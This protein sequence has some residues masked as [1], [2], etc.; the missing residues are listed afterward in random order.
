VVRQ[1]TLA[2]LTAIA[3]T[4]PVNPEAVAAV[5]I[6]TSLARPERRYD[7]ESAIADALSP[8]ALLHLDNLIQALLDACCSD[9][10]LERMVR[11]VRVRPV[12]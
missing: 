8:K 6:L 5:S 12:R 10:D 7:I 11:Q 9:Q 1:N 3:K 2:G 4:D